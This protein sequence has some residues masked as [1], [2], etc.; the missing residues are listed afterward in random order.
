VS[1]TE[2]DLAIRWEI[3]SEVETDSNS[4]AEK[5]AVSAKSLASESEIL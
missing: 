5:G 3:C 2:V 1:P 4:A